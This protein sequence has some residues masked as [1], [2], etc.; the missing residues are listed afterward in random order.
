[1]LG[2][3]PMMTILLTVN[4]LQPVVEFYE[5]GVF[6]AVARLGILLVVILWIALAL[7]TY[8]DARRRISDPILIG[9]MQ[10]KRCIH[11]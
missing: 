1:M 7:W 3:V 10:I 4:P 9:V 2:T 11:R 6:R 5:S 8:K